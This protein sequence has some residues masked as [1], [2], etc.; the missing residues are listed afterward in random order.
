MS[1]KLMRQQSRNA[2]QY[3]GGRAGN[4]EMDAASRE[5]VSKPDLGTKGWDEEQ[6]T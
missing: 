3:V 4:G 5:P 6:A 2:W 1:A